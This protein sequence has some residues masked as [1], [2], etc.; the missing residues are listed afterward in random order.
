MMSQ[1]RER[2]VGQGGAN[3][4]QPLSSLP[5]LAL[6]AALLVNPLPYPSPCLYGACR[7]GSTFGTCGFTGDI[8]LKGLTPSVPG[9]AVGQHTCEQTS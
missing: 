6:A 9:D 7:I 2:I 1:G 8:R 4:G 5:L 3:L